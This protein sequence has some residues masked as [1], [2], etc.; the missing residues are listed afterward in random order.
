MNQFPNTLDELDA[1][2]LSMNRHL[3]NPDSWTFE[4]AE[5]LSL[6]KC[7]CVSTLGA[8]NLSPGTWQRLQRWLDPFRPYGVSYDCQGGESGRLHFTLHQASGFSFSQ[9]TRWNGEFLRSLLKDLAGL[10]IEFRGLLVTPTGIAIRGYPISDL[11]VQKLMSVRSRLHDTFQSAGV[12]FDPPYLNN[13]CH[14][15]LFRWTRKPPADLIQRLQTQIQRWDQSVIACLSPFEWHFGYG[16][17][18]LRETPAEFDILT[19]F[20]TPLRIAHRGLTSGPN[21]TAENSVETLRLRCQA[22]LQSEIDIWWKDD[23]FW[24]GHDEPREQVT[25]EFLSSPYFWIHAKH[26]ESFQKLQDISSKLALGLR[27]FYHTDEDYVLTTTGETIIYPGLEDVKG[28]VYMMPEMGEVTP[29]LA[30][31][32]CSDYTGT[33]NRS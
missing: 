16:S 24:I 13:I 30:S 33:V 8:W 22:G 18:T 12:P 1:I 9:G 32:I 21:R 3:Q 26:T 23:A 25:L 27:V 14:A 29:T 5:N 19:S 15:T 10:Q 2:Y 6:L 11:E 28:W 17:L 20:W 7:L 4:S 31:A